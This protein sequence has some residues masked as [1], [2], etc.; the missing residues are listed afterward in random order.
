MQA[1]LW[2]GALC[3]LAGAV[4]LSGVVGTINENYAPGY[5]FTAVAVA[6]LGRLSPYGVVASALFF[7]ALSAGS[8]SMERTAGVSSVLVDVI[9]ATVLL[10]LLGSQWVRWERRAAPETAADETESLSS[11]PPSEEISTL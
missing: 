1:M 10:V 2:S 9:Q 8:G 5:G 4:E 6:L 3:G 7:G 11:I